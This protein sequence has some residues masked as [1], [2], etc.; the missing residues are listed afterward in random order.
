MYKRA[1]KHRCLV[2]Q[3]GNI[4]EVL[5]LKIK[6]IGVS[7]P[8]ELPEKQ[9]RRILKTSDDSDSSLGRDF[10]AKREGELEVFCGDVIRMAAEMGT[11]VPMTQ[12]Y[13]DAL[14]EIAS[15]F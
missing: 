14:K 2:A 9:L 12:K 11:D 1:T 15:R 4:Q 3:I 6:L 13:Y 7:L 10:A 8:E 5:L